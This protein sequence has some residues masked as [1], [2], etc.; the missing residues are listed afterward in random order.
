M[1]RT[2][3]YI[4]TDGHMAA[5]EHGA[6]TIDEGMTPHL[7]LAPIVAK[8]WCHQPTLLAEPAK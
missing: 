2:D 6:A 1:R 4:V 5:I 3:E 7:N 8:E